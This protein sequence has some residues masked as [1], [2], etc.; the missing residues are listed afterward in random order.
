MGRFFERSRSGWP[1]FVQQLPCLFGFH[2]KTGPMGEP[3]NYCPWCGYEINPNAYCSW[4]VT[5]NDGTEFK[6]D[7]VSGVHAVNQICE[8]KQVHVTNIATVCQL[9]R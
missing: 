9:S 8:D 1:R 7:A 2:R 4:L 5:L 3:A 6:I